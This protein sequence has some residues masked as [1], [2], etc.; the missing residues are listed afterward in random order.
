MRQLVIYMHC[1]WTHTSRPISDFPLIASSLWVYKLNWK[2]SLLKSYLKHSFALTRTPHRY[3]LIIFVYIHTAPQ[4]SHIVANFECVFVDVLII[5]VCYT[6]WSSWRTLFCS[7]IYSWDTCCNSIGWIFF[8]FIHAHWISLDVRCVCSFN[9]C[10]KHAIIIYI[11]LVHM[12]I[13]VNKYVT[14]YVRSGSINNDLQWFR[15]CCAVAECMQMPP[16]LLAMFDLR[17]WW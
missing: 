14:T 11:Y 6:S 17:S 2:T 5:C 1:K 7:F 4:S 12:R 8:S 13:Y 9:V 3:I 15:R 16:T 10:N